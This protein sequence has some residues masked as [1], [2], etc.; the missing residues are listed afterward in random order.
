MNHGWTPHSEKN[1]TQT[2]KIST[3][4]PESDD[5]SNSSKN[6]LH[7]IIDKRWNLAT[8]PYA[9]FDADG[10]IWSGDVSESLLAKMEF[11]GM[12][13]PAKISGSL[14]LIP[15]YKNESL[16]SYYQRLCDIDEKIGYL[17][18]AMV[19]SGFS[20]EI[21]KDQIDDLMQ[22]EKPIPIRLHRTDGIQESLV[23]APKVFSAQKE[24]I[25]TLIDRGIQVYVVTAALEVLSR[26]IVSNP[27]YGI[28]IPS[29]NVIGVNLVIKKSSSNGLRIAGREMVIG[30][31]SDEESKWKQ[32][33]SDSLFPFV[34]API[35]M[36]SGKECAIKEYI[37]PIKKPILVAGNSEDD[38]AMLFYCNVA[39]GGRR[40]FV[41][42]DSEQQEIINLE[43]QRMMKSQEEVN[44]AINANQGWFFIKPEAIE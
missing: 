18:I 9:V 8:N 12:F 28:N 42:R 13:T 35:S 10:T 43:I 6:L 1:L 4:S 21:L 37:H 41:V 27:K 22:L 17:W 16:Y 26:L 20:L 44:V 11:D 2:Q 25:N 40:L 33:N 19:F 5:L 38:L 36:S 23:H 24:L 39:E 30:D 15:F 34:Y 7:K 31:S 29:Q 3:M 32:Y 14:K